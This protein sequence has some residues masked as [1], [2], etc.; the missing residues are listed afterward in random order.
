VLW[1]KLGDGTVSNRPEVAT[2]ELLRSQVVA[3]GK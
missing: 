3:S 2:V 1:R